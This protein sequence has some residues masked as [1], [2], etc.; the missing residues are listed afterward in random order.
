M[1]L[2]E[3]TATFGIGILAGVLGVFAG[4][5]VTV[6]LPVLLAFGLTADQ[7]NATSR[8]SVTV[9]AT[10]ATLNLLR[11]KG[12]DWK[13]TV[14]FL[15]AAVVGVA[16]GTPLGAMLRSRT[17]LTIIVLTSVVSMI[18]VYVR[19]NRWL[20]S[21]NTDPVLSQ[22][23]GIFGYAV[24]CAYGGVSAA[25][26]AILRLILLVP[27]LGIPLA[28]ANPIKIVTTLAVFVISSVGY[29]AIGEVRWMTA[30][31]LAGGT[32]IGSGVASQ[33]VSSDSARKWVYL[34]LQIVVTLETLLLVARWLGWLP[35][36]AGTEPSS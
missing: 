8:V 36:S 28:R 20:S 24:I 33:F 26:N 17:M 3:A 23:A 21:A 19:P 14:P 13:T 25:D 12:I 16:I 30:V 34:I 29:G 5:G 15:L 4:G 6:V 18:L 2:L 11:N 32:A 10:I 35:D 9:G 22:R 27:L 31:W 1:T 7:A